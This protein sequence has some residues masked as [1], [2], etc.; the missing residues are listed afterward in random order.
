MPPPKPYM[1]TPPPALLPLI[2]VRVTVRLPEVSIPPPPASA[3]SSK[4]TEP[5]G[6]GEAFYPLDYTMG[7]THS[8]MLLASEATGD[9]RFAEYTRR[10]DGDGEDAYLETDKV[11][12]V[13][14]YGRYGFE[15]VEEAEVLGVANWFMWRSAGAD[16][17]AT[18][19]RAR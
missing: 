11:E 9:P 17:P 3:H 18:R 10:L 4:G 7:V 1:V 8:G 12:N 14:L 15:V 5:D 6:A 19:D 2:R 16:A 13:A